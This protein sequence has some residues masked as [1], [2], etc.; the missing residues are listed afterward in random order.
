MVILEGLLLIPSL[1]A[2]LHGD[3]WSA[4]VFRK[5]YWHASSFARERL[6]NLP[7]HMS[8]HKTF[9]RG[10]DGVD[11]HFHGWGV[12]MYKAFSSHILVLVNRGGVVVCAK[13]IFLSFVHDF[14][15]SL[16]IYIY[17]GQPTA[18][19]L[20]PSA[21]RSLLRDSLGPTEQPS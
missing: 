1:V 13:L 5:G 2:I 6:D 14:A 3:S 11:G 19:P 17:A 10:G 16:Y 12:R 21:E 9:S 15:L 4:I 20:D 8:G 7:P 18:G